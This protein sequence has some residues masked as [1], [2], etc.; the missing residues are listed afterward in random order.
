MS[1]F[2]FP[3]SADEYEDYQED[4][5][6]EVQPDDESELIEET[7]L[8]VTETE[9][10][11]L[12]TT[13]TSVN[14]IEVQLTNYITA[15][16][17]KIIGAYYGVDVPDSV[18][19]KIAEVVRPVVSDYNSVAVSEYVS[20]EIISIVRE[21]LGEVPDG[22]E[23]ALKDYTY[24]IFEENN[25]DDFNFFIPVVFILSFISTICLLIWIGLW[26]YMKENKIIAA[27]VCAN[28]F[29]FVMLLSGFGVISI[30]KKW[31]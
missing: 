2:V 16:A 10:F 6:E 20:A 25:P 19:L 15:R 17:I 28:L 11:L 18:A 9:V 30:W 23:K 22:F 21:E 8:F 24:D 3:V 14:D 13:T 31:L 1:F 27:L 29:A 4:Y 26:L 12:E 7:E 5:Y